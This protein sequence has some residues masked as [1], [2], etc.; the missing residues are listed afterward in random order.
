M[1][2]G[3]A[4]TKKGPNV[5]NAFVKKHTAALAENKKDVR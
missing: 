2:G 4:K 3:S 1:L 5:R